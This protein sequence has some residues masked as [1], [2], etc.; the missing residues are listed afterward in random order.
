MTLIWLFYDQCEQGEKSCRSLYIFLRTTHLQ[1]VLQMLQICHS[2]ALTTSK[3]YVIH[4]LVL[5]TGWLSRFGKEGTRQ[6]KENKILYVTWMR[7]LYLKPSQLF[8]Y[9]Q[10]CHTFDSSF[11]NVR[12]SCFPVNVNW[13]SLGFGQNKQLEDVALGFQKIWKACLTIF[14]HCIDQK[15]NCGI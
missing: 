10:K 8:F 1:Y 9:L 2:T 12:I 4:I 14:W 3:S 11:S 5:V 6:S 7:L 13:I 15:I